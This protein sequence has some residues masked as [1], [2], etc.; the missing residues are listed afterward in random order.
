MNRV[1]GYQGEKGGAI[2]RGYIQDTPFRPDYLV[3]LA[4]NRKVAG[5]IN[6]FDDRFSVSGVSLMEEYIDVFS[7]LL[8]I[9]HRIFLETST[10]TSLE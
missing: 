7:S 4:V 8:H 10:D 2:C 3:D 9:E 6:Y 1:A 5:H